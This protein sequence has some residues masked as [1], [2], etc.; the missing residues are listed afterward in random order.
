MTSKAD[1]VALIAE[2]LMPQF[3]PKDPAATEFNFRFTFFPDKN[4]EV[5]FIK[6]VNGKKS[7]WLLDH[8]EEVNKFS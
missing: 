5:Y 8:Y 6:K 7:A 3:I 2:Q 4:Y 1:P